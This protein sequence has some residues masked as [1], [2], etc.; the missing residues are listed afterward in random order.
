MDIFVIYDTVGGFYEQPFFAHNRALAERGLSD[1]AHIRPDHPFVLHS[2]DYILYHLG[3]L[4]SGTVNFTLFP[5][6]VHI[7]RLSAYIPREQGAAVG[8]AI[9]LKQQSDLNGDTADAASNIQ[10]VCDVD[11]VTV[12]KA[13]EVDHE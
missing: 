3:S 2:D 6:P 13:S 5:Q 11:T 1:I 8:D 10:P 12:S 7:N 9:P 4:E